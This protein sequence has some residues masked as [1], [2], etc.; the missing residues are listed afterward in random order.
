MRIDTDISEIVVEIE[1]NE[2]ALA[3][4]TVA[5]EEKLAE[6]ERQNASQPPYKLWLAE[7]EIVLGKSACRTLFKGGKNENLDRMRRIF[8][9]VSRAFNHYTDQLEE[10]EAERKLERQ[11]GYLSQLNEMLRNV[12][13]FEAPSD[14]LREIPR[15]N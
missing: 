4:R 2:Y 5:V 7:L 8:Y 9:Y 11:E 13:R 12:R 1:G 3:P 15:P 10:E 6:A 14:T